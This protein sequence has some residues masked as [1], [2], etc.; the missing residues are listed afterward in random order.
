MLKRIIIRGDALVLVD[1]QKDFMPP[2]GNLA[3]PNAKEIITRLNRYISLFQ[4]KS[5]PIFA[6]RDWH[7]PGHCSFKKQGGLWPVHCVAET[8]GAEFA[9]ELLLPDTTFIISKGTGVNDDGYSGFQNTR[10]HEYLRMQDIENIYVGGVATEYCVFHT[11]KDALK[12]G[13]KIL[14]LDDA[15][16]GVDIYKAEKKKEEMIRLGATRITLEMIES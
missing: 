2:S 7:P 11:V 9:S 13:Y 4:E 8:E 5:L 16:R 1:V 3:V 12:L 6:T 10:L 14:L 15:I